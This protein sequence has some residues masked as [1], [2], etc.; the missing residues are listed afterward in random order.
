MSGNNMTKGLLAVLLGMALSF[1]GF[2]PID[3]TPRFTLGLTE[4]NAGIDMLP[5]M[6]GLFALPQ[7]VREIIKLPVL[8]KMNLALSGL[9]ITL[10]EIRANAVN[11]VRSALIGTGIGVLPGIGGAAS[12]LIAYAVAKK[13][14]RDEASFG[15]GNV[16]G[17]WASEAA[18]NASIGGALLPLLALG[19][20]GDGVTA[21]LIGGFEIHGLQPGPMLFRNSPDVIHAIYAAFLITALLVLA[22]QLGTLGLFPR[23]LLIPRHYLVPVLVVLTAVGAFAAD[24]RFFDLWIMLAIGI[25]GY[26]LEKS[27]IPLAPVVLGFVMC[28]LLEENMRMALLLTEGDSSPFFTRPYAALFSAGCMLIIVLGLWRQM[29]PRRNRGQGQVP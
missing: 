11:L 21:M 19:I 6:V 14:S 23:I 10:A 4:L 28:P 27:E 16:A 1:P 2:S 24:F 3:G 29:A 20:P 22:I 8:G 15:K 9:G 7:L 5:F 26:F 18:N 17:V 12:N 25:L 13:S